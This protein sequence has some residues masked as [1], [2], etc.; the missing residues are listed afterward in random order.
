MLQALIDDP[1]VGLEWSGCVVD[2]AS[3]RR[4][5]AQAPGRAL[6][7]AS[8]GK[9]LLLIE[10]A[11]RFEAGE[12]DRSA[13]VERG[14]DTVADSGLWQVMDAPS[15]GLADAAR[16]VGAVSDN[17][18]TNVLLDVVGLE[19]VAA[20]ARGLGLHDTALLDRVRDVRGPE[21]PPVLS[22]GSA[23]DLAAL[24][25]R[26]HRGEVVG[27]EVS[28]EVTGW[29]G[30][31]SD[32]SMVAGEFGLDPLA[33][34]EPDRGVRLWNKTGTDVSVRADVGVVASG[35]RALAYAVLAQWRP[36]A[37]PSVRDGVLHAMRET[38]RRLRGELAPGRVHRPSDRRGTGL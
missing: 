22:C 17:L 19:A 29:L 35:E 10:L 30:L 33:H 1:A 12:L 38:G 24:A 26:L 4:L 13:P 23:A 31:G 3:G 8:V 11:R 20:T 18:A 37:D 6:S 32:L 28:A 15:L 5:A 16:L 27:R 14:H 21:H 36:D 25:A 34:R 9:V 2:A 7:T